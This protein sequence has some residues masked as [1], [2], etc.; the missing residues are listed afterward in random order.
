MSYTNVIGRADVTDA[1]IPD[2]VVSEIIQEA[3]KSSVLLSRARRV[4]M[5]SKKAK[6]P[7]LSSLPNAYWVNGDDGMKQTSKAD[8]KNVY[9]TAEELAVIVPIPDALIDDANIPLWEQVRPLLAEA[10]GTSVDS[11]GLFGINKPASWPKGI[12]PSA[13]EAG[14][15]VA[16]LTCDD[17]AADVAALNQ[18]IAEQGYGVN[19]F[20]SKP[21][22]QWELVGL[23]SSQG[24]PIYTPSLSSGAPSG[25]YGYPLNESDNGAWDAE[26][27]ELLAADWSKFVIGIRQDITYDLFKEGVISDDDGK[28]II[29]LMQQDMKALRV[30]FRVGFQ[31]AKPVTRLAGDK[32]Y[33]AGVITPAGTGLL[34]LTA[35]G[36]T[37]TVLSKN[38]SDIQENIEFDDANGEI[39]G[40]LKYVE[41][42]TEYSGDP[43][44]QNGHF[45]A[46]KVSTTDASTIYAALVGGRDGGAWK[47][48]ADGEFVVRISDP[49]NQSIRVKAV[50][51][52]GNRQLK[53]YSLGEL[54]FN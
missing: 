42:W 10:I 52:A 53:T 1:I 6:Q 12:V 34:G 21:G 22:M 20:A 5:S 51:A 44:L 37:G 36:M 4:S 14:N 26:Q 15:T 25:L 11:A 23:R 29:N 16:K 27:A 2:Q 31:V 54:A 3:P 30:V 46:F 45:I 9:I 24:A 7:V 41:G 17:I 38:V 33:P 28:I 47:S 39:T 13:I 49:F 8:W 43:E 48:D 32:G 18:K 40:T 50:D 35:E 19:G